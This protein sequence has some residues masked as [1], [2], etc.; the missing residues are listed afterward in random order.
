MSETKTFKL[1]LK[2]QRATFYGPTA[3][4]YC[5]KQK[6]YITGQLLEPLIQNNAIVLKEGQRVSVHY[7]YDKLSVA[8][9]NIGKF[10]GILVF[11][12]E[13]SS[14][15]EKTSDYQ[16]NE[17]TKFESSALCEQ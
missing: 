11:L 2:L 13:S 14:S 6:V 1:K 15:F 3:S 17:L 16:G 5:S 8:L 10:E 7:L 4:K 12:V 9:Q